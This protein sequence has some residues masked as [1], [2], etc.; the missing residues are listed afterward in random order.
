[1]RAD[2]AD[3]IDARVR[4]ESLADL[5]AY[6]LGGLAAAVGCAGRVRI[7]AAG[8]CDTCRGFGWVRAAGWAWPAVQFWFAVSILAARKHSR[9]SLQVLT[10]AYATAARWHLPG[11]ASSNHRVASSGTIVPLLLRGEVLPAVHRVRPAR[12]HG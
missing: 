11:S 9:E 5:A 2:E 3:R 1:V 12:L 8:G 7:V 4:H 10:A 6:G